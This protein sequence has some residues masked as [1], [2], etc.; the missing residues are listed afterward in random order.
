MPLIAKKGFEREHHFSHASTTQHSGCTGDVESS[1]HRYAKQVISDAGYLA[2]PALKVDLP[3]PDN[4][5]SAEIPAKRMT[6]DRV[7]AE[8]SMAFGRRRVDVVGYAAEG[9]LLIEICVTHR[10]RGK[11]LTE[12]RAANEA[13]MEIEVPW[14]SL[15]SKFSKGDGSLQQ[16]ILDSLDKK[17]WLFHPEAV[18]VLARLKKQARDRKSYWPQGKGTTSEDGSTPN[19]AAGHVPSRKGLSEEEYVRAMHNF[20]AKSRYDEITMQR[21]INALRMSGNISKCDIEV[22]ARLGLTL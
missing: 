22:A 10:V 9:R 16:A 20:L 6:F 4:D 14:N 12:V 7:V 21:I 17:R 13:M 2:V 15:Y 11:K 19:S 8:E 3:P 18:D 5:L 1:I